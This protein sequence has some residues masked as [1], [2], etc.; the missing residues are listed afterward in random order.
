MEKRLMLHP[1]QSL[2]KKPCLLFRVYFV[3][4]FK[5]FIWPFT[6]SRKSY[7]YFN[8]FIIRNIKIISQQRILTIKLKHYTFNFKLDYF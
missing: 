2:K 7:N 6:E 4:K 5:Y 1:V 3:Y 8:S